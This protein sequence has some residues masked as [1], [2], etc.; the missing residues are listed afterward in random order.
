[1]DIFKVV[2]IG[3]TAALF[4][5]LLKNQRAELSMLLSLG[6]TSVIFFMIMPY[7]RTVTEMFR[8]ISDQIGID[9][10]YI[11]IVLRVIGI[12]YLAQL[13]AELCRDAGETA[14]ASKIEL[15]GKVIILALSMPV[16]YKLLDVVNT[17]IKGGY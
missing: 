14:I 12:A 6:A 15:A 3:L 1:M 4:A 7:I 17:I 5:V 2:G 8:D 16:M 11:D 13:G 10:K 9:V